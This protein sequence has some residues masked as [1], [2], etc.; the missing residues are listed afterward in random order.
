[1]IKNFD[2]NGW[3]L[4]SD[5]RNSQSYHSADKKWM[6]KFELALTD[7]SLENLEKEKAVTE[8]A[9][10]IGIKTPKVKDIVELPDGRLG[11]IYEYIEGK[12]SISRAASEDLDNIDYY[13]DRFVK[14]SKDFHSKICDTTKVPNWEDLIRKKMNELPYLN[15]AQK[16]KAEKLME[17]TEKKKNALLGDFHTGNF[18]ITETEEFAIDLGSLSYGNPIYDIAIFRWFTSIFP[19]FIS[20]HIFHC[21]REYMIKM[22]NSFAKKYFD[23]KSDNELNEF[24]EAI[25]K[26][27][28]IAMLGM[29]YFVDSTPDKELITKIYQD[30]FDKAMENEKILDA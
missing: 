22:W 25:D 5:R 11:L 18:I 9:L 21:K 10:A 3:T 29:F 8:K 1:M 23:L 12:K 2:L 26:Y 27:A 16:E 24:N 6:V 14:V 17:K 28:Y 30:G 13:M 15:D 19:E 20:E 7:G 4:F